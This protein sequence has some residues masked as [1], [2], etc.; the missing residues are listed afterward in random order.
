MELMQKDPRVCGTLYVT[1]VGLLS[2][3]MHMFGKT[4]HHP[5][6]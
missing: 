6:L 3:E 4:L 1:G 5:G 2:G